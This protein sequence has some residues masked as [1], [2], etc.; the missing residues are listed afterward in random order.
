MRPSHLKVA[1]LFLF[2]LSGIGNLFIAIAE[3]LINAKRP[4]EA[5]NYIRR[6][7]LLNPAHER[8]A[9]LLRKIEFLQ[10]GIL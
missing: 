1:L 2:T 9:V 8:I 5:H 7:Q 6:A 3:N 10:K 4:D